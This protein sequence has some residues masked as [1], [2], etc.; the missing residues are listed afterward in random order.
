IGLAGETVAAGRESL[1]EHV[2][3]AI[4]AL[5]VEWRK[6]VESDPL[7]TANRALPRGKLEDHL[8]AWLESFARVLGASPGAAE[9]H[10][11]EA[12]DAE[13]HG[14]QRWQQGYDLHE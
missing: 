8:P 10:D 2:R 12:R 1:G 9:P 14:V 13:A 11:A 7:L 6:L 4:P 3:A 5:L